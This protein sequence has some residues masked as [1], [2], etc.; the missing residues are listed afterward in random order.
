MSKLILPDLVTIPAGRVLI[1][2]EMADEQ[3]SSWVDVPAFK[4]GRTPIT[5]G[6]FYAFVAAGGAKPRAAWGGLRPPPNREDHPVTNC[7]W[8]D[9]DAYCRWLSQET[10]CSFYLP[11]EAEWVRAARGDGELIWPW[12]DAFD[13]CCA[14]TQEAANGGTTSVY[15]HRDGASAFGLLDM[16]GNVWEWTRDVYQPYPYVPTDEATVPPLNGQSEDQRRVLKG[17]S[18]MAGAE[19]AR[20][21]ARVK[22]HANVIFSGQVGFRVAC[23]LNEM[24]SDQ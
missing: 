1:G 24:E 7:S 19:Y 15:A 11:L 6:E 22:W 3:P 13:P 21:A 5:A 12:G 17:G 14:N 4:I 18:W 20:C 8:R 10:G 9:A 23:K 16:A 2:G